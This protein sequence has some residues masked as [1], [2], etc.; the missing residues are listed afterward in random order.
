ML[1]ILTENQ[2]RDTLLRDPA[3]TISVSEGAS[4]CLL[5]GRAKHAKRSENYGGEVFDKGCAPARPT[6]HV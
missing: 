3:T 4:L 6:L 2:K 5:N 1:S